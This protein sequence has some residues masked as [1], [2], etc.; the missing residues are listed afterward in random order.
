[1]A[2]DTCKEEE[3][4]AMPTDLQDSALSVDTVT[5][6]KEVMEE[7]TLARTVAMLLRM[8]LASANIRLYFEIQK[9]PQESW[10]RFLS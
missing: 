3:T 10:Q 2:G 4:L 5:E 8:G 9:I 1:M 7:G 6:A